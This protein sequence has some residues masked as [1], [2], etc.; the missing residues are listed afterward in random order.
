MRKLSVSL[1]CQALQKVKRSDFCPLKAGDFSRMFL[2]QETR[3]GLH[4]I[5]LHLSMEA[6]GARRPVGW[7]RSL[8]V[9]PAI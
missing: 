6:R 1:E 7:T 4:R 5:A 9:A 2:S 8:F 3:F